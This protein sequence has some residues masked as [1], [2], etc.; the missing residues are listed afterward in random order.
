MQRVEGTEVSRDIDPGS[1]NEI[2]PFLFICHYITTTT[3]IPSSVSDGAGKPASLTLM[4]P[5]CPQNPL[6]QETEPWLPVINNSLALSAI[7]TN[8]L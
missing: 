3:T 1:S 2:Y 6:S 5:R 7:K 8:L 4:N